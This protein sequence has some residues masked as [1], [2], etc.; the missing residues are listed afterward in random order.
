M[1]QILYWKKFA[2]WDEPWLMVFDNYDDV[3]NFDNIQDFISDNDKGCIL[4]T[5]GNAASETLAPEDCALHLEGL[6]ENDAL[7][8]LQKTSRLD[9]FDSQLS[10]AKQIVRQLVCHTLAITQTGS[11]IRPQ[12]LNFNQFLEHY[13][14]KRKILNRIPLLTQYR[15]RLNNAE[16]ETAMNVFTTESCCLSSLSGA[17][18][19][20]KREISYHSW[21][22]SIIKT[23]RSNFFVST[24]GALEVSTVQS[25]GMGLSLASPI[26]INL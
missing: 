4:M 2:S 12:K 1:R 11:Y 14:D 7:E 17:A 8:L 24:I 10:K 15:K 22:F 9:Q 18:M 13:A 6:P 16:K 21:H 5:G 23:S 19:V 26:S 20:S 3:K 25:S